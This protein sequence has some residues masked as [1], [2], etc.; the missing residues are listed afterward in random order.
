MRRV[1]MGLVGVA[2]L[3]VAVVGFAVAQGRPPDATLSLSSGS[4]AAGIGY[5]WGSGTLTYQGREYQ[6]KVQGLSVGD[7]GV[8]RASAMGK[9]YNLTN[10]ADFSGTYTAAAA[11]LTLADGAGATA[12]KNEKGVVIQ[13]TGTSQGLDIKLAAEGVRLT[14]A[15]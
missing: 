10:L 2:S 13:L 5:T 9:V 1:V 14:L 11:G 6:V 4:V 3:V 15:N 7:V 8:T 12:M